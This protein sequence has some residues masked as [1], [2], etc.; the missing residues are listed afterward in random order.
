MI[1]RSIFIP[2]ISPE[3]YCTQLVVGFRILVVL[4]EYCLEYLLGTRNV[5]IVNFCLPFFNRLT[6]EQSGKETKRCQVYLHAVPGLLAFVRH[7]T[8][9][10]LF[11]VVDLYQ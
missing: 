1:Y 2:E 7:R 3:F 8:G 11:L 5:S 6:E 9:G 4:G 10:N